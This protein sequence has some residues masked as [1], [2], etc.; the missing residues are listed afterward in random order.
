MLCLAI[1]INN[2]CVKPD[3]YL[4]CNA[5]TTTHSPLR[6]PPLNISFRLFHP[7]FNLTE[8]SACSLTTLRTLLIPSSS[9]ISNSSTTPSFL[10]LVSILKDSRLV[11]R[12]LTNT[13]LSSTAPDLSL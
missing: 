9:S 5:F 7:V 3:L 2:D 11:I 12:S 6:N 1:C 10:P 8:P 13:S 4:C